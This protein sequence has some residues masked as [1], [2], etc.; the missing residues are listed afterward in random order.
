MIR[1]AVSRPAVV[2]AATLAL[3]LSGAMAFTRLA[4]ASKTTV[5]LPRLQVSAGWLGASAELMEM[6]IT[7]P[8]ESAVQGVRGVRRTSSASR[9]G[10]SQLTV[11]LDPTADVQLARLS[12][13]ERLELLRKDFPAGVMTPSVS[14][15]VPEELSEAPLL[16]VSLT[17]PYTKG[18]LQRVVDEQIRPRVSAVPGVSAVGLSGGTQFGVSVTYD[19]SLLRQLNVAPGLL[20][21]AIGQA[22]QVA[23]LGEERLGVRTRQVVL[24]DQPR[25]LEE[26]QRLPVRGPGGRIFRLGELAT[27]RPEEDARN[28]FYRINGFPA[29]AFTVVRGAGAD[30]IKTAK[31][32]RAALASMESQLP[33]G[34]QYEIN[35]DDSLELARELRDLLIRGAIAFGAVMLVL[36]IMLRNGRA[37]ALVMAS[38]AISITGTA[39]GLYI[40][41]IPANTLT[42]AGLGMGIGVLVQN[43][44]VVVE[45]LRASPDTPEGRAH[46][47]ELMF[48][49]VLGS[50]LTTCVVLFPFLYLQGNARAAFAP[51]AAAFVFALG[52]SVVGAVLVIPALA[53]R[54]GIAARTWP[55][56]QRMYGLF[57]VRLLRWRWAVLPLVVAGL[58]VLSWGFVKKVP[59]FAFGQYG[60]ERRTTISVH[61]SFPRG[62]DPV[63][64]DAAMQSLEA[65]VLHQPGVEDVVARSYGG[66]GA[67]MSVTIARDAEMSALPAELE[68]A[69]TQRAVF[70]GG[71][72]ISVRGQGPGF[73]SGGG[74]GGMSS[75]RIKVLGYSYAGVERLALDLKAR[76]E[77]IA[78]VRDV[79]VNAASFF[80]SDKAWAVTLE[81]DRGALARFG[82]TARDFAAAVSREVRGAVGQ[83]RLEINGD[84]L[85]VSVKAAGARER[86]LDELRAAIVP[87][88]RQAPVKIGDLARV[89]EA[90]ALGTISRENQQ[91]VRIVSYEFRG[92]TK[93]ADRTHKAFMKRI[94]V[95]P[96]YSVG[97]IEWGFSGADES[98]KGLWLV[99]GI[100]IT[101][102]VLAV[103]MVFD[104]AW[105]AAMVFLSLPIALG[106][107]IA[108]FWVMKAAFTRE[109]A[110]GVILV[111]GLAVHQSILLI[112]GVMRRRRRTADGG[113]QMADGG[114]RN[115]PLTATAIWRAAMERSAMIVLVTLTTLASLVPLAVGTDATSL[116]GAIALAT[117][118]GTVF[119]TLGAMVVVPVMLLPWGRGRTNVSISETEPA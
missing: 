94:V 111:V 12:I 74:G 16:R 61:L 36:V 39:L 106:G 76:L 35:T 78:R 56:A 5:E 82:V 95:P 7:S 114:G 23:A 9:D 67:D 1:W 80:G 68:E 62:S 41:K 11:E 81:P 29:I 99:F 30:A 96:G 79:N 55:R 84:E 26:L 91:Y 119:G 10:S 88:S 32:V 38:A 71:A 18:A 47:G 92:P 43:P 107:V 77:K 57:L 33:A 27:I 17:G 22:R 25:D 28:S 24:R 60:G 19:A 46:V 73:S 112:D 104:S 20:V 2:W 116:F 4:L 109:A 15:Y 115:L 101:L 93:L 102:V 42:L 118:G 100:G 44:L 113:R 48:P 117:V 98:E 63:T 110:V 37:V 58:G 66:N 40:F 14:N 105:A 49:A 83:Q 59:R 3:I 72:W 54:H 51:F 31:A 13:L 34:V 6:Y 90:E 8:V 97:D 50:T 85:P 70:V 87:T 69:L 45:R 75:Y 103:A 21:Q 108:A 53:A 86:S 65:V 89:D 64:L 52:W